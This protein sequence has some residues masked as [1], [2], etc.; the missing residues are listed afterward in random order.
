MANQLDTAMAKLVGIEYTARMLRSQVD[1]ASDF[2][3]NI[4][5]YGAAD[6]CAKIVEQIKLVAA[7][8]GK[9]S[10][11]T[12]SLRSANLRLYKRSNSTPTVSS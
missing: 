9:R 10:L 7:L 1:G 5:T 6:D 12:R 3:D 2:L 11:L 8:L 4:Q